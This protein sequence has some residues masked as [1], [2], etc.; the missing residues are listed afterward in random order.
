M[1]K[2]LYKLGYIINN[3]YRYRY[4]ETLEYLVLSN[5]LYK[6]E[7]KGIIFSFKL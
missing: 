6:K 1:K 5:S 2:Y 3:K 4:R 7:R